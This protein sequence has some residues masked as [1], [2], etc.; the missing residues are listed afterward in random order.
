MTVNENQDFFANQDYSWME[1]IVQD[2]NGKFEE[3]EELRN[4]TVPNFEENTE[5]YANNSRLTLFEDGVWG[6]RD[7]NGTVLYDFK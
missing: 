3:L 4:L 7:E 1:V 5:E 2:F 6:P